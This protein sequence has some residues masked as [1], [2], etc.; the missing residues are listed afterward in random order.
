MSYRKTNIP[1]W[2]CRLILLTMVAAPGLADE[3]PL[4]VLE[5]TAAGARNNGDFIVFDPA[6]AWNQD[7]LAEWQEAAK[8]GATPSIEEVLGAI[9]K[10]RIGP[11]HSFRLEIPVDRPRRAYFAIYNAKSP[12]G[13]T[14]GPVRTGNNFVLEPGKLNLRTIRSNYWIMTGG[15][16]ND[17]I[18]SSWR[19]SEEYTQAQTEY[20]R[21]LTPAEDETEE[22]RR[23]RVDKLNEASRRLSQ[24]EMDG[25]AKVALNHDDPEVVKHAIQIAWLF[26]PWMGEA[27]QR[28]AEIA[29]ED[30]WV[31]ERLAAMEA[32][33]ANA[34]QNR[35]LRVG[36]SVLDFTAE[37]LGGEEVTL[38]G[39]RAD[40]RYLLVEFWAS[41]C[42][43]CRVEIP[44]MKQAYA[45]FRDN[46]FEIVSFT[47]D[48][49]REDWEEASAEEDLPWFD[50]GM[51]YEAEAAKAYNVRGVP[52]NYLV[53]S[54]SGEIIAKNLRQHKLDEK[55][56]ELLD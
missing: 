9:G 32:A 33:A 45:R 24:I 15:Y 7:Q 12:D 22:A 36:E 16:Y 52:N 1:G 6:L 51:G 14:Y 8:E 35:Q 19:T 40:S 41:W 53:E 47:V 37:T 30:P 39:I 25:F 18:H 56:E 10:A 21:F 46:G 34:E 23:R 5:G 2:F 55:L 49:E 4:M 3:V 54:S 31:I 11:D 44:H 28:L 20:E 29:P 42:G 48:E 38:S 27:T 17:A 43:P 26:G 50:L 13:M